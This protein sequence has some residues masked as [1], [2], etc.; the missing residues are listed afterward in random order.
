M[1]ESC[2]YRTVAGRRE[3]EREEKKGGMEPKEKK[4]KRKKEEVRK[5]EEYIFI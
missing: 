5:P 3:G 1:A 4:R 2:G